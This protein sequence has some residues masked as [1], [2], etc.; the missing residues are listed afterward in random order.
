MQ[1]K[2]QVQRLIDLGRVGIF[3]NR[4]GKRPTLP[5]AVLA[6]RT[7]KRSRKAREARIVSF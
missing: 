5:R 3:D 4:D 6:L 7:K 1:I 2:S